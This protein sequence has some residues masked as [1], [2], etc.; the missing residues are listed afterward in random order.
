MFLLKHSVY[1]I[2]EGQ[3]L[4]RFKFLKGVAVILIPF[5]EGYTK[6]SST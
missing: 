3:K 4:L 1:S 2:T 5:A 6:L